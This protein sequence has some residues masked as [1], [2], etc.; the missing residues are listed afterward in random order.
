MSL[1]SDVLRSGRDVIL[2]LRRRRPD[3][4]DSQPG[5]DEQVNAGSPVSL[6]GRD[7]ALG[8]PPAVPCRAHHGERAVLAQ[9]EGGLTREVAE[10]YFPV[11]CGLLLFCAQLDR[12]ERF[13]QVCVFCRELRMV[14]F[15]FC[16]LS[17]FGL[18]RVTGDVGLRSWCI[19]SVPLCY[20]YPAMLHYKACART[21]K[22]KLADV[23]LMVFGMAAAT[24]TTVQTV[25]VS[26]RPLHI[27]VARVSLTHFSQ[28]MIAPS[29]SG[30][31]KLG[32]CDDEPQGL[33]AGLSR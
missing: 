8:T 11:R 22:Q 10:E 21:R 15:L 7:P 29:P 2:D 30:P 6:L 32:R 26:S 27:S 13:G 3:C 18:S 5:H 25:H 28:L 19:P 33:F 24:Y 17:T 23:A 31:P 16:L 1:Y 12:C 14:C 4:S 9:R 20:V